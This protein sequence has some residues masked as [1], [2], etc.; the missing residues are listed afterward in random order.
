MLLPGG[1]E[2]IALKE[3]RT[4]SLSLGLVI[5][6]VLSVLGG[7]VLGTLGHLLAWFIWPLNASL[8]GLIVTAVLT[9]G[10]SA[11][12][13]GLAGWY[14]L[15][16]DRNKNLGILGIGILGG[17]GGA[18]AGYL[19]GGLSGG[20]TYGDASRI[21]SVFGAVI[22]VNLVEPLAGLLWNLNRDGR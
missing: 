13:G 6:V 14:D 2:V 4:A 16:G 1:N 11:G 15:D 8:T 10:V 19:L 5:R 17:I 20:G 7:A 3:R 21:A 18:W 12:I 22:G 9:T